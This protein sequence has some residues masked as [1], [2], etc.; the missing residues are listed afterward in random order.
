M[1]VTFSIRYEKKIQNI[2]PQSKAFP[3]ACKDKE[4]LVYFYLVYSVCKPTVLK[5]KKTKLE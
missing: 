1:R 4:N 5:N 2:K 3:S